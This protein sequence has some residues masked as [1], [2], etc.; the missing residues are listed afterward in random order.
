MFLVTCGKRKALISQPIIMQ[1][2]GYTPTF[3]ECVEALE[4]VSTHKDKP[5]EW[6]SCFFEVYA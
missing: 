3:R 4:S 6:N 2:L 5:V 1:S